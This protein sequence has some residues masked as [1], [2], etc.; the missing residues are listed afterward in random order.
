MN[1][2]E[3]QW[4]KQWKGEQKLYF[5]KCIVKNCEQWLITVNK[6][7]KT[8]VRGA[9]KQPLKIPGLLLRYSEPDRPKNILQKPW[10]TKVLEKATVNGEKKSHSN[11]AICILLC[12]K[13]GEG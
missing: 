3:K 5:G 7:W 11:E 12:Q 1:T 4:K 8:K 13:S 2:C 9:H 6:L 10:S